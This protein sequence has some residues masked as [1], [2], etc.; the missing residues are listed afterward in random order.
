M[1]TLAHTPFMEVMRYKVR[2]TEN[3]VA[4]TVLARAE[5]ADPLRQLKRLTKV[6]ARGRPRFHDRPPGL[7]PVRRDT[8]RT[9]IGGLE[10]YRLSL[11]AERQRV[12]EVYRPVDVAFRIGGLGALGLENYVVLLLGPAEP[13]P[14]V[15]QLKQAVSSAVHSCRTSRS[16]RGHQGRRIA[17]GQTRMQTGTDPLVGWTTVGGKPFVVRQLADHK[18]KIRREDLRGRPLDLLGELAGEIL[19]KAHA[20][21]GDA[22]V[23]AGYCGRSDRLDEALASFALAYA[24]Q[25]E[26]DHA[27]FQKA[28]KRGDL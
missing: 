10:A 25:T 6:D 28:R 26:A 7:R 16:P 21:T 3:A 13:D 23:I 12:L 18:A 11:P 27:A 2:R 14:L 19:A 8:A 17:E 24:D 9:V 22:A 15:L 1:Q 4:R 20:R 5:R